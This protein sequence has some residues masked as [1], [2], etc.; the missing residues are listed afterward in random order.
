MPLLTR[1][2]RRRTVAAAAVAALVAGLPAAPAVAAAPVDTALE[3][4]DVTAAAVATST[5]PQVTNNR[6]WAIGWLAAA[7]ALRAT[8][9]GRTGTTGTPRSPPPYTRR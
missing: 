7:R 6:A 5:R 1:A 2:G 4:Y 8:P 9:P 3:W